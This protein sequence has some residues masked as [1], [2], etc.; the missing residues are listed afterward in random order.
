MVTAAGPDSVNLY[1]REG[2]RQQHYTQYGLDSKKDKMIRP[3]H[4]TV[5]PD[6]TFWVSMSKHVVLMNKSGETL[7]VRLHL[8]CI[9]VKTEGEATSVLYYCKHWRWGYIC[10]VLL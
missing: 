6:D 7:K 5:L 9:I 1:D 3:T 8:Y 2:E 4:V 10:T